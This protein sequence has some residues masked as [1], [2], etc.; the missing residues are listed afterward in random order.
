MSKKKCRKKR[1]PAVLVLQLA[2]EASGAEEGVGL[3]DWVRQLKIE[4]ELM[5]NLLLH[6]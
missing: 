3:V 5:K 1:C 4:N 2:R 6:R